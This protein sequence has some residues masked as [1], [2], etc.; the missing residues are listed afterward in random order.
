VRLAAGGKEQSMKRVRVLATLF[1]VAVAGL[2][3]WVASTGTRSGRSNTDGSEPASSA[4]DYEA[5]DV[6][7]KQMGPDGTLQYEL[8]ARKINQQPKNGQISAQDLVMHH[9]PSGSVPGGPD[10]WT[11]RAD[12]ADLPESEAAIKLQGKVR[13][14][15]RLQNWRVPVLVLTEELTYNLRTQEVSITKPVE[16]TWDGNTYRSGDLR[17]NIKSGDLNVDSDTHAT[18]V[19]R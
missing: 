5:R 12:S 19:P 13:A 18:F 4:Y 11:L 7:V 17:F 15:G 14:E 8:T 2:G 6:V 9:D 10:R 3:I 16:I 1:V